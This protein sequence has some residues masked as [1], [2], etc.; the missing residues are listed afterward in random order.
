MGFGDPGLSH[1]P[2]LRQILKGIMVDAGKQ[3]KAPRSHLPITPAILRKMKGIW[4]HGSKPY[5]SV[6]LWAASTVNFFSF[7]RSGEITVPTEK[8]F[9][10]KSHLSFED[11]RADHPFHPQSI[12]L[13]IKHSKTDQG[14]QGVTLVIGRTN[15]DL[16]PIAALL[17][18]LSLRGNDPGPLF[19][20]EDGAPLAKPR[21]AEEVRAALTAANLPAHQFAG[22][23]FR[24]GAATTA[25][26]V[27]IQDSTIQT[28]GRWKSSAYL[29][30]I[31]LPSNQLTQVAA[32]LSKCNM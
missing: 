17:D 16:C 20:W 1:M 4:F 10:K 31:K 30:Y 12:S 14:R 3:G 24:R 29:L 15:D 22:H 25:A 8:S 27:G 23:S 19:Q 2:R 21:F 6:M 5:K 28:L 26:M 18:Y 13:R 9:D 7:C 32:T 11:L